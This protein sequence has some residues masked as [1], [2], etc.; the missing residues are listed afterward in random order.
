MAAENFKNQFSFF[1]SNPDLIY[2]DSA[3]T[4]LTPDCVVKTNSDYYEKDNTNIHRGIYP[5]SAKVSHDYENVRTK[6]KDFIKAESE[7]EVIFTSGTTAAINLVA[8]SFLNPHSGFVKKHDRVI[9]TQAEHHANFVV[10]QQLSQLYELDFQ[11][12]K[13]KINGDLD[14][15]HFASLIND[16]TKIVAITGAS[17]VLGNIT[18]LPPVI[19]LAKNVGAAVLVDAAQL[20]V[21]EKIDV[22]KLDID[23][24]AFSAHKL[25][26]PTGVGVLWGRQEIMEKMQPFLYGGD[27]I[28]QV[29]IK[30]TVFNALPYK[31]EAGTPNIAGVLG[32]G[33]VI[34]FINSFDFNN[35]EQEVREV[36]KYALDCL[37]S[38]KGARIL[39]EPLHRFEETLGIISFVID[40]VHSY[41]LASLLGQKNI[42]LRSG[43]HCAMPLIQHFGLENALRI[44][45]A[46]YNDI[47]EVDIFNTALQESLRVLN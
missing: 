14:L 10:W 31:F 22:T 34:D 42:C 7:Q 18:N 40:G 20:I 13:L 1:K 6:V 37:K 17:N 39:G 19:A 44:S 3:A 2:F 27:M 41:D 36:K 15:E 35:L 4:A 46:P 11:V 47:K 45:F 30:S 28:K 43:H 25:Y 29:S 12:A 9:V 24:L 33:V 5:L 32:L 8:Y 26:G 21:H 16:K 38:V 23:F